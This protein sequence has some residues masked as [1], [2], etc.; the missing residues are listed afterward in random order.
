MIPIDDDIRNIVDESGSFDARER[1]MGSVSYSTIEIVGYALYRGKS[2]DSFNNIIRWVEDTPR[3]T[4]VSNY[5]VVVE[6]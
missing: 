6:D 1:R 2:K 4:K 3:M 5:R